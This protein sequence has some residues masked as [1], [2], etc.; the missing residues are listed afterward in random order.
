M[1][2]KRFDV[3][4]LA[5]MTVA[6]VACGIATVFVMRAATPVSTVVDVLSG[7]MA[8]GAGLALAAMWM[9]FLRTG[10]PGVATARARHRE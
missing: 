2:N 7:M 4:E 9:R 6:L 10:N 8:A 1:L 3:I 5:V